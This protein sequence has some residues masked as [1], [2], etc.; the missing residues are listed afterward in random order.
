MPDEPSGIFLGADFMNKN[1]WIWILIVAAVAIG[2]QKMQQGRQG[3]AAD[4][5]QTQ[6]QPQTQA[7]KRPSEQPEQP[8][9]KKSQPKQPKSDRQA[10]Q[11][12]AEQILQQAFENQ[13]SDIQVKGAGTVLKTLPDDN[14]G[15]RH[16]R[17]I[18][19]L[20]SGQTL[21][22]AHNIDLADKIKDLKKGDKVGFYG[23]Y[24]WSEQGGVLHWTH[25]DPAG[26]H[27]DGWL[28]HN[29]RVYQ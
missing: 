2:Y 3:Q 6:T 14:Q 19:K 24:E 20:S 15:T 27:T 12:S 1:K 16:Q 22:V 7:Q 4:A 26:R 10:G 9:S 21:L 25:H 29:G 28:E 13:E 23:E 18:L 8:P 17:F 5:V 11:G